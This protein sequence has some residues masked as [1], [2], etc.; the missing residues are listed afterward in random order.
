[1]KARSEFMKRAS[2]GATSF[3]GSVTLPVSAARSFA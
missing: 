2:I 1:M 3:E